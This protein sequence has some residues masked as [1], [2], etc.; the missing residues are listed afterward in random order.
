MGR[1]RSLLSQNLQIILTA[2]R[3]HYNY[4]TCKSSLQK[5]V[6]RTAGFHPRVQ[7]SCNSCNSQPHVQADRSI[8][9]GVKHHN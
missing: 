9:K 5:I 8:Y 2:K 3:C 4:N 7:T 6:F 1:L